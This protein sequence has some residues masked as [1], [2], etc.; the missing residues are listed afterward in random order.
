MTP[1]TRVK[2]NLKR[3]VTR[4]G[5]AIYSTRAAGVDGWPDKEVHLG[6]GLTAYIEVKARGVKHKKEHIDRQKVVLQAL[7]EQ[8]YL[9]IYLEGDPSRKRWDHDPAIDRALD[10]LREWSATQP[11]KGAYLEFI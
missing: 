8:G 4:R 7:A 9:S 5:W 1:E 2:T 10:T 3:E 11:R 6:C